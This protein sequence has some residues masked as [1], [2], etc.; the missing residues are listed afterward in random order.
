M[1]VLTLI[2]LFVGGL[3]FAL[4]IFLLLLDPPSRRPG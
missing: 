4:V 2:L 1:D 3:C